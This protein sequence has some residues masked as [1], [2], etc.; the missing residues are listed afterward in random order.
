MW[1]SDAAEWRPTR[2]SSA[3]D[4]HQWLS[5]VIVGHRM[6]THLQIVRVECNQVQSSA[7]SMQS[8]ADRPRRERPY[9]FGPPTR[10]AR[11]P[12]LRVPSARPRARRRRRRR[13]LRATVTRANQK[14]SEAIRSHWK[15]SQAITSQSEAIRSDPKAIRSNRKQSQANQKRSEA[16]RKP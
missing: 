14:R 16:I 9:P 4:D 10:R 15:Q 6:A 5:A 3:S 1:H 11:R 2:S 7:I 12:L 13:R 8:P